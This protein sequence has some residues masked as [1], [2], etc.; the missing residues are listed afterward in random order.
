M[1]YG[2]VIITFTIISQGRTSQDLLSVLQEG[3]RVTTGFIQDGETYRAGLFEN[4]IAKHFLLLGT[5]PGDLL[6]TNVIIE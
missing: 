3:Q 5:G 2:I 4:Q 1:L 6:G